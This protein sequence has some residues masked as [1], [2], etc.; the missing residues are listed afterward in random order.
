MRGYRALS[1]NAGVGRLRS[2]YVKLQASGPAPA[3]TALRLWLHRTEWRRP[4]LSTSRRPTREA[5][6]KTMRNAGGPWVAMRTMYHHHAARDGSKSP[7]TRGT[8]Q[9]GR[10]QRRSP[11]GADNRRPPNGV[12]QNALNRKRSTKNTRQKTLEKEDAR[13]KTRNS[14]H[15]PARRAAALRRHHDEQLQNH[16]PIRQLQHDTRRQLFLRPGTRSS[17]AHLAYDGRAH[18][19]VRHESGRKTRDC[20]AG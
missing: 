18:I 13:Q 19:A 9:D 11:Q 12:Q 4:D 7:V 14:L 5:G 17:S 1:R 20:D 8:Q 3:A 15:P 16:N 10:D 6:H 2:A